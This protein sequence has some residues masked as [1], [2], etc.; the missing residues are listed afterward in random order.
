[1]IYTST[2]ANRFVL[3]ID[4]D[5]VNSLQHILETLL[6]KIAH[7]EIFIGDFQIKQAQNK[8]GFPIC[9]NGT[10]IKQNHLLLTAN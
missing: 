4:I 6:Q 2:E 1:M 3:E 5:S 7:M 8:P 10:A 9:G